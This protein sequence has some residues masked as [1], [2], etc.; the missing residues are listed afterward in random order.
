[1]TCV[2]LVLV[3]KF[4][5]ARSLR[6][7][8]Y[9]QFYVAS[10]FVHVSQLYAVDCVF[11]FF[12][13]WCAICVYLFQFFCSSLLAVSIFI[14]RYTTIIPQTYNGGRMAR[15]AIS[16]VR[17]KQSGEVSIHVAGTEFI[18]CLKKKVKTNHSAYAMAKE[19]CAANHRLTVAHYTTHTPANAFAVLL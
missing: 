18:E 4:P 12:P 9:T 13:I 6:Q 7:L 3:N 15:I 16:P 1:M 11:L 8:F 5:F 14:L 19:T 10:L 17:Q 2:R